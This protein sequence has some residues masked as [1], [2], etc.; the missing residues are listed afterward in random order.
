[1]KYSSVKPLQSAPDAGTR[2]SYYAVSQ[3]AKKL[4]DDLDIWPD[5]TVEEARKTIE[6][7]MRMMNVEQRRVLLERI[8]RLIRVPR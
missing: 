7:R 3:E 1:M 8:G 6:F 4:L 2:I 5:A